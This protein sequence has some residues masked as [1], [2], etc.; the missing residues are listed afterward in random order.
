[1]H[2]CVAER[3]NFNE[4]CTSYAEKCQN[5]LTARSISKGTRKGFVRLVRVF[6]LVIKTFALLRVSEILP[7]IGNYVH[8]CSFYPFVALG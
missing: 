3:D 7:F 4:P 1:M 5:S 8:T 6:L 2:P